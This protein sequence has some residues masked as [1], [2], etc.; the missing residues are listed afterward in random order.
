MG[1]SLCNHEDYITI[2]KIIMKNI[3][4]IIFCVL[5]SAAYAQIPSQT[6]SVSTSGTTNS[7]VNSGTHSPDVSGTNANDGNQSRRVRFIPSQAHLE[8]QKLTLK[9]QIAGYEDSMA[10]IEHEIKNPKTPRVVKEANKR[11]IETDQGLLDF[12]K[13]KLKIVQQEFD[14]YYPGVSPDE[15]SQSPTPAP[16]GHLLDPP[17]H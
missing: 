11:M 13:A 10:R 5:A 8:F 15:S 16:M 6:T 17:T 2:R 1:I 4:T 14:Q 3:I 9:R 7:V 12:A